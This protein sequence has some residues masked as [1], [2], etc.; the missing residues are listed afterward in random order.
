MNTSSE[1]HV[2][3][4]ASGGV[5]SALVRELAAQ[6]K[7]VRAVNR[8]GKADLP[9]GVERFAADITDPGA[10]RRACEG[11]AVV[12]HCANVPYQDWYT[13]LPVFMDN[14]TAASA[15]TGAV[16]VY[17]DNLYMYGPTKE[18]LREDMPYNAT[19]R[20]GQLRA[21]LAEQLLAAHHAGRV[22]AVIGRGSDYFGP[23]VE[24]SNMGDRVFNAVLAG[25]SAPILGDPDA[26]HT[27][28]YTPDFARGLVRLAE[29]EAAYGQAWHVPNAETL[30]TRQFLELA[31]AEAGHPLKIMA[32]PG[33][34]V[35]LMGL[36]NPLMREMKEMLYE[37]EE[38]FIVDHA[39]FERAFGPLPATPHRE[40]IRETL[41]SY[42][43]N[44]G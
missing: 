15:E 25:Q 17:A 22:R 31:Y 21:R 41:V 33:W 34:L 40:A 30:T 28:T 5:G 43:G 20:K 2:V 42:R 24:G 10:A 8:S 27:Y 35:T 26:P 38:P 39:R 37:F 12:Y 13:V 14:L 7:R 44:N 9:A 29:H 23:G 11:A 19:T 36:F 6:G 18:P 4:G 32:A 16:L 1:Y 3:I